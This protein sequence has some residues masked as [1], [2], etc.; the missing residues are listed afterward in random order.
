[1][2]VTSANKKTTTKANSEKKIETKVGSVV[3][4]NNIK[5]NEKETEKLQK[6]NENLRN[7]LDTMKAQMEE[8]M[9][10]MASFSQMSNM[11]ANFAQSQSSYVDKD[12]E[13]VSLITGQ[14]VLS[15]TGRADGKIYSFSK[16]FEEQGIPVSDL[17]AI[18]SSM[19]PTAMNGKFFINDVDFVREAGL[20]SSYRNILNQVELNEIFNLSVDEFTEKFKRATKAQKNIIQSMVKDRRLNGEFVDA[21]I[22]MAL[23]DMT[24]IDYMSIEKLPEEYKAFK[25]V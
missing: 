9:K 11:F 1:M 21:N 22:M 23:K 15:T 8:M 10:Q 3:T 24:G 16:Q 18:C 4:E 19:K 12:I 13:V 5:T 7:D 14:L 17:K 20:S 6:E 2:A 25:E